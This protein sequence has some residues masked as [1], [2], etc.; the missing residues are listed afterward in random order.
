MSQAEI[1]NILVTLE[2]LGVVLSEFPESDPNSYAVTRK[3]GGTGKRVL[4]GSHV[5]NPEENRIRL[6]ENLGEPPDTWR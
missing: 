5:S 3:A 4:L 2:N 6:V 1:P